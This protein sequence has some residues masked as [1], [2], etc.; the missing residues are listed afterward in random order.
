MDLVELSR[1]LENLVR[2]GTIHAVDHG[3][4]RCRVKSGGLVTQWLPWI[5]QRAGQTTT[6]D[7]P[8][9]GEQ[10]IV[11]SPSGEAA[12]GVVLYGLNSDAIQPPS[13][14]P[15]DHVTEYPDGA[16]ISYNH[17]SGHLEATGIRTGLIQAATSITL[18]TPDVY[19]TGR[20]TIDGLLTYKDGLRGAG[21]E[22]NGNIVTGDF[23]HGE[24]G[25][26]SSYGVILH[27]HHHVGPPAGDPV[28]GGPTV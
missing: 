18:D 24:S 21:G 11:F 16:R 17:A 14:S 28:P 15:D 4:V 27:K 7:P 8:T 23:I 1:R 13:H 3:A 25:V 5:P 12:G 9:V 26:L 6:W 2:I 19:C 20:V 10:C 22:S